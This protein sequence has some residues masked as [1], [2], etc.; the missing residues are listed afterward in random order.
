VAPATLIVAVPLVPP[1]QETFVVVV[2]G[3]PWNGLM[4]ILTL[5]EA[6]GQEPLPVV[7]KVRVTSPE[8]ISFAV[9]V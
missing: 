2:E 5:S 3:V 1:L 8:L 9:G 7:V 6:D 4:L